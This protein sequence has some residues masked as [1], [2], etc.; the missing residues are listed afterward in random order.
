VSLAQEPVGTPG[1]A[2]SQRRK[3]AGIRLER[4]AGPS[5][6]AVGRLV[7]GGAAARLGFQV[8]QVEDLQLAV[9]ALLARTPAKGSVSLE[10]AESRAGLRVRIG[11]LE[12]ARDD[13]ERVREMLRALVHDADVQDSR[14][15][16]WIVLRA[17]R[18]RP[19]ARS[20]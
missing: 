19:P 2:H 5:Y 4:P 18:S 14:D 20:T 7:V 16:E 17:T 12:P 8:E 11:P 9:E 3:P 6:R 13:W 15:E 1:G 10:L